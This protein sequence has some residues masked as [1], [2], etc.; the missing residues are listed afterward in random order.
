VSENREFFEKVGTEV[1]ERVHGSR[2][3]AP[4]VTPQPEV[5]AAVQG[6]SAG[7]SGQRRWA[8]NDTIFWAASETH[9]TLPPGTYRVD[10][11]PG[12]GHVLV[13]QEVETDSLMALP[14]TASSVIIDEFRQFW[15]LRP[16]F[17]KRGFLHKRGFLLWGPPGCHPRGTNVIMFDGTTKD[18][19]DVRVGD[20]L[21]GPDSK[22]RRVLELITGT[23]RIHEV[24]PTKGKPFRV[25][26]D[27]ILALHPSGEGHALRSRFCIKVSDFLK[28]SKDFQL[29]SKLYRAETIDW[30]AAPRLPIPPY[31]LGLWLG[32]GHAHEPA[33]TT[34]DEEV[35]QAWCEWAVESGA[36]VK[37]HRITSSKAKTYSAVAV[38]GLRQAGRNPVRNLFTL[39]GLIGN[40]HIPREYLIAGEAERLEL[41]AG[42]IDSDGY[43]GN[44]SYD[45]I[46][47]SKRLAES[48][49]FLTRSLGFAAYIK[50]KEAGCTYLG[51]RKT[52]TYWRL[53]IS[54]DCSRIPTRLTRKR[55]QSRKQIKNHL[56]TGFTLH[57]VG[58]DRY[59]G[60]TLSGDHLY[61]LD[62]FTVT[63]NSGKT[64]TVAL[65]AQE[66]VQEHRGVVL[67]VTHPGLTAVC[68]QMIRRVEPDRPLICLMEDLD[69]L[70]Q[71][72]GENE[73]LA[74]L[75]GEAQV[76]NVC[77]VATTNYPERLDKR[78][79]DRPSRFDTVKP[80]GMPSAAARR[81]YLGT[82]EPSLTGAEL[83]HWVKISEGLSVAHLKEMIIANRCF[84]QPIEVVI[85]R[86][87]EMHQ[88]QPTSD[89]L[90]RRPVGFAIGAVR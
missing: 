42:L 78:F 75:D 50:S 63:H 51:K 83:E 86:L 64:S 54:G 57:E 84:G 14:D 1:V 13:R 70:V 88:R 40:K 45:F 41:L 60:F 22:P 59:Y 36:A 79:V 85:E 46:S 44:G 58:V 12:I 17:E 80:I 15:R 20:A 33:L 31:I 81:L 26:E 38:D 32:D 61:L 73:Y 62:D 11:V 47:K 3:D 90:D 65:L 18:V 27:H 76:G 16:E 39:L 21:M 29:R 66:L 87:T 55:G 28:Q 8:A 56:V 30:G 43:H 23:G 4:Q 9:D 71:N 10:Q 37:E 5:P 52:G 67:F 25:N 82:K 2:A 53:S 34:M 72:Y 77:F 6:G 89:D 68:L 24:R 49:L 19:A 35:R 74:L 69:A 7:A 48:V